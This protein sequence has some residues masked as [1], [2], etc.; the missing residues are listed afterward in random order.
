MRIFEKKLNIVFF[1]MW[2]FKTNIAD[3]NTGSYFLTTFICIL[4]L[5]I[6][7]NKLWMSGESLLCE[8]KGKGKWNLLGKKPGAAT[9]ASEDNK[10]TVPSW[11]GA[12]KSWDWC[13]GWSREETT[14]RAY[15][16]LEQITILKC[17]KCLRASRCR[18]QQRHGAQALELCP[19][20]TTP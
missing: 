10:S 18:R 9:F 11:Q 5:I 6:T 7:H 17:W 8:G 12:N 16:S 13:G 19:L 15:F 3:R 4:F 14:F 20:R 1:S 2:M